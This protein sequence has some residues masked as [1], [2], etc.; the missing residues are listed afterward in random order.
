MDPLFYSESRLETLKGRA[1]RCCCKYCGGRLE[2]RQIVFNSYEE[3]RVEIFCAQCSRIEY[4]VEQTIYDNAR[5][6]V[7]EL[8]YSEHLEGR[9]DEK[10]RRMHVAKVCDIL[11]WGARHWG[12]LSDDGFNIDIASDINISGHGIILEDDDLD[13]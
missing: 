5:Y 13:G 1:R 9:D 12:I 4:G 2:I 6:F 11:S 8:R 7:E 3:A 10:L